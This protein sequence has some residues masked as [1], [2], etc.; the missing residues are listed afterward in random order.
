VGLAVDFV[1]SACLPELRLCKFFC[2]DVSYRTDPNSTFDIHLQ[3]LTP[4]GYLR[5]VEDASETYELH[6]DGNR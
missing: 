3:G 2:V 1:P 5:A 4:T 6:P